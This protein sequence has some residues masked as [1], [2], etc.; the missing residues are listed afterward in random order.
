MKKNLLFVMALVASVSASAQTI[1]WP[2]SITR[3]DAKTV[4]LAATVDGSTTITASE[5]TMGTDIEINKK[6]DLPAIVS[7]KDAS[8]TNFNYP[9]DEIGMIGWKPITGNA[10]DADGNY[11][12][13]ESTADNAVTAGAYIDFKI[14]ETDIT[15][16]L[17]DLSTIAFDATKV[18]TD[19][20]RLNVKVLY[21]GDATGESAWLIN[22]ENAVT[23]GDEYVGQEGKYAPFDEAANGYNPSRNDGS[24]G[25]AGG[26]NA[27]GYSHVT[28]S[29]PEDVKAANPYVMT[30]RLAII[31]C[32]NNKQLG[33][34]NLTLSANSTGI[35]AVKAD[36]IAN[37]A[38]YNVA[39]QKVSKSY[40]GM[41]I[42]NGRKFIQK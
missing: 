6:D 39:G 36:N 29:I 22:A 13:D 37:G 30:V 15:K 9:S 2:C 38:L 33:I 31:A 40:K 18:G 12:N 42:S 8:G 1:V 23:F 26:A 3:D 14:E 17:S 34:A 24:K 7:L 11:T 28:V 20:I 27:N 21:E 35:S 16:V 4:N 10:K 19:A 5:I 32:A 41:V 25:A